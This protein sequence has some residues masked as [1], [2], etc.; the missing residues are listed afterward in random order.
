MRAGAVAARD[1]G[2][3]GGCDLAQGVGDVLVAGDFCGIGLRSDHDKIVV[4]HAKPLHAKTFGEEFLFRDLVVNEHHVGI[5]APADVERLA[6][7]DCH[8]A[9]FDPRLGGEDRQQVAK[10]SRLL[11]RGGRSDGD[12]AGKRGG[13]GYAHGISPFRKAAAAAV[14]GRAKN[15]PIGARSTTRPACR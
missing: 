14:A 3:L 6:G 12:E 10:E 5:A 11:G 4:H 8:H 15:C 7:A 2:R 1:E 9:H 13:Q